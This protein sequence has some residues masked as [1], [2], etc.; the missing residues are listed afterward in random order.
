VGIGPNVSIIL[1]PEERV[2]RF[3]ILATVG[4][5]FWFGNEHQWGV[6]VEIVYLALFDS[7]LTHEL[8]LEAGPAFRF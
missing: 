3:G 6:D 2:T 5:Y 1:G 8:T 4:S 7:D